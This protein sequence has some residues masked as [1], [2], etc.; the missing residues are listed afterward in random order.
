M[1]DR[2]F[3]PRQM[4]LLCHSR[5]GRHLNFWGGTLVQVVFYEV[6]QEILIDLE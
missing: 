4:D 6:P 5:P 3:E 2:G 1:V